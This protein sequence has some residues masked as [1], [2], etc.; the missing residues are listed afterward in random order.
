MN[1]LRER[2][3]AQR[4]GDSE[5]GV[6]LVWLALMMVVLLGMGALGIDVAHLQHVKADA[7]KAADAAA[8]AGAVYLPDDAAAGANQARSVAGKNGFTDVPEAVA[9]STRT[10]QMN[11]TVRKTVDNF[12]AGVLGVGS[13]TVTA[14]ASAEYLKPVAMGSPTNQYGNDPE[15]ASGGP[16]NPT[17][18]YPNLWA[19]VEG[20]G[21]QK[22]NGDAFLANDCVADGA[23][24][25]PDNCSGG[26][27]DYDANGYYYKVH[28][29][30]TATVDLQVFDPGFVEVG[31]SCTNSTGSN[32]NF[33]S[34]A[35]ALPT[36]AIQGWPAGANPGPATRYAPVADQAN[37]ADPGY[38]Y[39][40]GDG[41]LT[42]GATPPSTTFRVWGPAEI[43][44]TVPNVSPG[45]TGCGSNWTF[46][47]HTGNIAGRLQSNTPMFSSPRNVMLG[48]YFRQWFTVCDSLQGQAGE[49]YFI[50]V[51]TNNG[52]GMN[53]FALRARNG[54]G[55]VTISGNERI[56]MYANVASTA[57][58]TFYLARIP[59][60]AAGHTLIL[61]FYDIGDSD[62]ATGSVTVIP[63]SDSG[64]S[65]FS[66]C[67]RS[68]VPGSS[69][70]PPWGTMVDATG[71]TITGI[72]RNGYNGQWVEMEIPIPS[73]YTC[74]DSSPTGCWTKIRY[75]F[76]NRLHDVT[77]WTARLDGDPVRIVK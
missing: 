48:E 45:G 76:N 1:R 55:A 21:T 11:V 74:Q 15:T 42:N 66:G 61:D 73:T 10:S 25:S 34:A 33:L 4:A 29:N 41:R 22:H 75:N 27:S 70:G 72:T 23:T 69:T 51:K 52:N 32:G 77:S 19:M 68:T 28:F 14:K 30:Q 9:D 3:R 57:G 36:A 59:S 44:G 16:T 12:L 47:G 2:L 40:T 67:R 62:A 64:L 63:P 13:S 53:G 71:C 18:G 20:G 54:S 17:D 24:G 35:A 50:Q 6:V 56:G 46:P 5:G 65:S 43:P 26:N 38:K 8:L 39:C 31:Q 7:Q 49:D 58:S 60:G 37:P